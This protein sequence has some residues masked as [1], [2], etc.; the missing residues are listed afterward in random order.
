M[1]FSLPEGYVLAKDGA[2]IKYEQRIHKEYVNLYAFWIKAVENS[3][4]DSK[5]DGL[6]DDSKR[7]DDIYVFG[8]KVFLQKAIGLETYYIFRDDLKL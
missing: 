1:P 8:N 3:L 7:D 5:S 2:G 4:T 6:G